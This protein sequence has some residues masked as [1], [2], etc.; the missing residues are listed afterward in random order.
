MFLLK[1]PIVSLRYFCHLG[2][3]QVVCQQFKLLPCIFH[4]LKI[5]K[6]RKLLMHV[7]S[8]WLHSTFFSYYATLHLLV[9][10]GNTM[11]MEL[12]VLVMVV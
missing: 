7:A 4:S 10:L 9:A 2:S 11:A 12:V 6:E 1:F 3:N 8:Y 5:E